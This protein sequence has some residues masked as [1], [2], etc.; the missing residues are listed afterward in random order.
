MKHDHMAGFIKRVKNSTN[1]L[2]GD[3]EKEETNWR[4]QEYMGH[5]NKMYFKGKVYDSVDWI[6]MI[7][8]RI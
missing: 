4:I 5:Y 8:W 3:I 6:K 7:Q 1:F 2:K